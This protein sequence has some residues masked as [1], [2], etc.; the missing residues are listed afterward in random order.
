M[1]IAQISHKELHYK[2]L[3]MSI[4][5]KI[6]SKIVIIKNKVDLKEVKHQITFNIE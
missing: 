5:I 3:Q 4:N 2:K 1:K 6:K